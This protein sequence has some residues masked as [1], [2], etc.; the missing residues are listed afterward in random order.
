MYLVTFSFHFHV[1]LVSVCYPR[2]VINVN[3]DTMQIKSTS[4]FSR[5]KYSI[6][7]SIY[8]AV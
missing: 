3:K 4:N 6:Y 1:A 8:F 5:N 2:C 7:F